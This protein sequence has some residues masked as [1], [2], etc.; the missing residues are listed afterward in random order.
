MTT[1]A[2]TP[3]SAASNHLSGPAAPLAPRPDPKRLRNVA[4]AS[5]AG[6]CAMLGL[7]FASV[8]FYDWFCRATGYDGTTNVATS[9][10]VE[11]GRRV[12]EV[13]F[14]AN[15]FQGLPWAF[16]PVQKSVEVHVGEVK[17]VEYEIENLSDREISATAAYNVTPGLAGYY[18][19]KLTC[20]CFSEQTLKPHEKI[21]APVTFF[22]D[23]T[24]DE[25]KDLVG[26]KT[27]TLSY[28]FFQSK[29]PS[30]TV[31]P[32]ASVTPTPSAG[33]L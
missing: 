12:F 24:I 22:V 6:A 30:S 13:R 18:F 31:K 15:V 14:D 33:R 4:F 11:I 27:I 17:T 1:P 28:T 20:F 5:A 21:R 7:A 2:P 3:P 32:V 29:T 26:A 16:R 10:P 9:A 25:V 23:G 8:P 19:T